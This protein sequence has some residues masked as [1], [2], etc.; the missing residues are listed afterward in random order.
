MNNTPPSLPS[1]QQS[2]TFDVFLPVAILSLALAI[3]LV[4]TL[5]VSSFEYAAANRQRDQLISAQVQAN[6][7]EQ[8]VKSLMEGLLNLAETDSDA[9]AIA[10]KYQIRFNQPAGAAAQPLTPVRTAPAAPATSPT[11]K[12]PSLPPA[13]SAVTDAKAPAAPAREN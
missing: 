9:K 2:V 4:W 6:G 1:S 13:T 3:I 12:K 8:K 5:V 10:E 11:P 7:V